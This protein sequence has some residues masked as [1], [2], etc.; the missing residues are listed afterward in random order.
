MLAEEVLMMRRTAVILVILAVAVCAP[1]AA[2]L[3]GTL[4][5]NV[6]DKDTGE[7]LEGVV[8]SITDKEAP[9]FH[10]E[11]VTDERGRYEI[12]LKNAVPKYDFNL[13]KEGYRPYT[14][15]DYKVISRKR[16]R[17]N[18]QLQSLGAFRQTLALAADQTG[19]VEIEAKGNHVTI[20]NQGHEALNFGDFNIAKAYFEESLAKKAEYGPAHGGMAR[21]YEKKGEWAKA[22]EH[23]L[24]SLEFNPSDTD[25]NQ[26][27][28]AAYNA[29]GEKDKA[30]AAL[31][32]V[33]EANPEMAGQNLFNQA[34][35]LYN[36]GDLAAAKPIFE[37]VLR[38]DPRNGKAHYMLG[39]CYI[40]EGAN[41]QAKE[42]F[43]E[44]LRL[45]PR[46]PDAQTAKD[47][48]AYL[49]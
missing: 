5:G 49:E 8:I 35:D 18:F 27:L 13:D 2:Q 31:A 4:F 15:S 40:S 17:E 39:L 34:A 22:L 23:A 42:H 29:L 14:F 3:P 7:P 37:R 36:N 9:N 19:P 45:S 11:A 25:M 20:Y 32:R 41:D 24:K 47:M 1:M 30:E 12:F 44:F 38:S 28:Y 10:Q 46:D 43:N 26:V 48:L 33:A 16:T 6:S 21:V